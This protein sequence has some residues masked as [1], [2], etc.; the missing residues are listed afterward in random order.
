[1][2]LKAF[3]KKVDLMLHVLMRKKGRHEKNFGGDKCIYYYD[4]GKGFTSMCICLNS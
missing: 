3:G 1:M 2:N 4:C